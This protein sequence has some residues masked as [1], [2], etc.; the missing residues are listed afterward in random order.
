MKTLTQAAGALAGAFLV[1]IAAPAAEPPGGTTGAPREPDPLA[2]EKS[3]A[4]LDSSDWMLKSEAIALLGKWKAPEAVP[5]L[6]AMLDGKNDP[7]LAG[8]ALVALARISGSNVLARAAGLSDDPVPEIRGSA[9]E[10]LGIIGGAEAVAAIRRRLADADVGVRCR[11]AAMYAML[12]GKDA[13]PDVAG[14]VEQPPAEALGQAARA[15]G[16]VGTAESRARIQVLLATNNVAR[17]S[18]V[19]MGLKDTRDAEVVLVVLRFLAGLPAKSELAGPCMDLLQSYGDEFLSGPLVVAFASGDMNMLVAACRLLYAHPATEPVLALAA[20]MN[21][22]KD[23]SIEL[24]LAALNALSTPKSCPERHLDLFASYLTHPD[25]QCRARAATCLGLCGKA[26]LYTL[27]RAS[28]A[29]SDRYVVRSALLALNRLPP[30]SA[31]A[32][33]IVGYLGKLL[34]KKDSDFEIF[35]Y[36]LNLMAVH[37]KPGEFPAALAA[38]KPILA[39]KDSRFRSQAAVALAQLGGQTVGRQV[40]EAQGYLLDWMLIGTFPNDENNSGLTNAYPPEA[41]IDFKTNYVAQYV[42]TELRG[43]TEQD[44]RATGERKV[45]WQ[46]WKSD[47]IDGKVLLKDAMP[48]PAYLSVAYGVGDVV[49]PASKTVSVTVAASDAFFVWLNGSRVAEATNRG[50][51]VVQFPSTLKEGANRIM[52]K[53]CNTAGEWWYSVQLTEDDAAGGR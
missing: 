19:L 53:S 23:P 17:Q 48:P 49:A 46:E 45:E 16:Y 9:V 13:W 21:K 35:R 22:L 32:E 3:L 14:L 30:E 25:P 38:L 15:L 29:D 37:G 26:D 6:T 52:M 12:L 42:W 7:W 28:I 11:A 5:P 34:E 2:V 1:A 33:G 41:G 39:G 27:L 43:K 50:R 24:V 36:T 20:A 47:Q 8:A 31:P 51:A 4:Q 10:A 44:R 40:A 18:A